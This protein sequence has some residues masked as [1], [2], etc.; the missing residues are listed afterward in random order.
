MHS[1][2]W[3]LHIKP[4]DNSV[5]KQISCHKSNF[6]HQITAKTLQQAH[7]MKYCSAFG[8]TLLATL[9]WIYCCEGAP[10]NQPA[11]GPHDQRWRLISGL[12]TTYEYTDILV[13][14]TTHCVTIDNNLNRTSPVKLLLLYT[15][16]LQQRPSAECNRRSGWHSGWHLRATGGGKALCY[17]L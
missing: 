15:A 11:D 12:E 16:D 14:D 10:T 8:V 7:K 17:C 9:A 13:S 1:S 4:R 2:C 3:R 5:S 6:Q